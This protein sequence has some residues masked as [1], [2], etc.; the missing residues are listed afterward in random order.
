MV[1]IQGYTHKYYFVTM[2]D[3]LDAFSVHAFIVF[4]CV[5]DPLYPLVPMVFFFHGIVGGMGVVVPMVYGGI[6]YE[7][8]FF[9]LY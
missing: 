6:W 7:R 4:N 8:C 5:L 9:C 1:I 2:C 3:V